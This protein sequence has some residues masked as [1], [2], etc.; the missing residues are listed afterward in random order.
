VAR[1]HLV[2]DCTHDLDGARAASHDAGAQAVQIEI[3]EMRMVQLGYEHGRH[4]VDRR[5]A[6][7]LD[8]LQG[9]AGVERLGRDDH[10]RPVNGAHQRPHHTAETVVEGD[11]NAQAVT[12]SEGEALADVISVHE[13]VAMGQ[14]GPLGEAGGPG[15]VLDA[16][17]ILG[18]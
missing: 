3:R 7:V 2:G 5:A 12:G 15:G 14:H 8:R 4:S 17:D 6:L 13:Q 9:G 10:G 16:D 18:I 1:A 11:W